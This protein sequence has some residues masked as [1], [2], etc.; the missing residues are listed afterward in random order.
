M[1][2]YQLHTLIVCLLALATCI[3]ACIHFFPSSIRTGVAHKY[4]GR[5]R[6][7][8]QVNCWHIECWKIYHVLRLCSSARN[9]RVS[10]CKIST[11]FWNKFNIAHCMTCGW[12]SF[13]CKS[14]QFAIFDSNSSSPFFYG[15]CCSFCSLIQLQFNLTHF[16][17]N[18]FFCRYQMA[19][20]RVSRDIKP[21][22]SNGVPE[23]K[24]RY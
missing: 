2:H 24:W 14:E 22:L 11:N 9:S 16:R 13:K 4:T 1:L 12:R 19:H 7:I 10:S 3:F 17:G 23:P 20:F 15:C 21:T 6:A 18:F 5:I 8:R